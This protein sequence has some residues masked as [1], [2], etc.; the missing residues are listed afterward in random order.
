MRF[1]DFDLNLLVYLDALLTERSVSR[2]AARVGITQP[3]MSEALGRLRGHFR[4]Q[5]LVP[6]A[7][8][9]M[10]LTPLAQSL[11][12]QVREILL[13]AQSVSAATSEFVPATSDRKFTI[14]ASDYVFDVLLRKVIL[15]LQTEAPGVRLELRRLETNTSERIRRAD[16]DLLIMPKAYVAEE[17]PCEFL[18]ED[19]AVC[20]VWS[21]NERVGRAIT[22]QQ[23]LEMG[24]VI[25]M[26]EGEVPEFERWFVSRY[27]STRR[28][29]VTVPGFGMVLKSIEGTQRIAIAHR[30]HAEMYCKQYSLRILK[31]PVEF[32]TVREHQQW[33]RHQDDDPGLRWL[34][35][36]IKSVAAGL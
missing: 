5:I 1:H 23:Y 21:K 16:I 22:L 36:E 14:L 8:R 28:V 27:G 17:L 2:A 29:E 32:P 31:T 13:R 33:H 6:V 26:L 20:V 25:Q 3:A 19:E 12:G 24:H 30:R 11:A 35:K 7:G 18:F 4:D 10:V 15:R 34:R 9:A